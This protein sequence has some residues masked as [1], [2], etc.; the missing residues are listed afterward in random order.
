MNHSC[1]HLLRVGLVGLSTIFL[2]DM[3]ASGQETERFNL[4]IEQI[5]QDAPAIVGEHWQ[6]IDM[7]H[8]PYLLG[9]LEERLA[10]LKQQATTRL[11]ITPFVRLPMEGDETARYAVKQVLDLGVFGVIFPRVET[12][13]QAERAVSAMRYPPQRGETAPTPVGLRGWG[14]GRAARLWNLPVAE[15]VQRADLWPLDP[16]GELLAVIMI[17]SAEGVANVEEIASVA[18]VGALFIGPVDLAM[19][20]GVGPPGSTL[21]PETETAIQ[22]VLRACK[23]SGVVCGMADS[24]TRSQQRIAEGFRLLLPF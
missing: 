8:G 3:G 13:A 14:P 9:R 1:V 6:F 7:E 10:G 18:G 2:V 15:Y 20:L 12:K 23:N 21:A 17:E 11:P 5:E 19:S 16:A 4:V 22:T 24:K